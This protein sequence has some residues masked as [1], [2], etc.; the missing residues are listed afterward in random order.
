MFECMFECIAK[1]I[2]GR[3]GFSGKFLGRKT[4]AIEHAF[5]GLLPQNLLR[6]NLDLFVIFNTMK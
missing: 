3:V 2:S 6:L 5:A 4:K 1:R